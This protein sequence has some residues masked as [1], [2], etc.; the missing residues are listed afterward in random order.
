M[1]LNGY[2][3]FNIIYIYVCS[4]MRDF[5]FPQLNLCNIIIVNTYKYRYDT[6][7]L[8]A[9]QDSYILRLATIH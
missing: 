1:T 9:D 4:C 3:N 7:P 8:R 5:I 6:I 2:G